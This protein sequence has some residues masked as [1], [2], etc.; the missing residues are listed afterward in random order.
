LQRLLTEA[1]TTKIRN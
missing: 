1:W